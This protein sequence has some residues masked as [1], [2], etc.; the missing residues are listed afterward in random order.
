MTRAAGRGSARTSGFFF[1]GM[2]LLPVQIASGR[3]RKPNSWVLQRTHSSAQP[4]RCSAISVRTK[5][6]SSDEVAVAGDVQAVGRDAVEARAPG[7]ALAVDRQRC[8]PGRAAPRGRTFSRRRQ[9]ATRPR[10][11]S[12]FST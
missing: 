5:T 2:M 3:A 4:E 11:R 1:W 6:D 12:S 8:R 9:S 10:S 7:H